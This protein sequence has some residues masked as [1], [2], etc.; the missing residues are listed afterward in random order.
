MEE[1]KQ[2]V[3]FLRLIPELLDD[4][5]WTEKEEEIVNDHFIKLQNLLKEGKLILAGRT[6]TMVPDGCGI[7]IL[8]VNNEEEAKSIMDNDPAVKQG[9]MTSSLYPYRVALIRD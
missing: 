7:V 6:L 2:F 3:Y 5:N 1:K 8:E 4:E 9:I